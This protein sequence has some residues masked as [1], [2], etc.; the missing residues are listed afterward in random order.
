ML[1]N[2]PNLIAAFCIFV[3]VIVVGIWLEWHNR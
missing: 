3:A 2:D 1:Y